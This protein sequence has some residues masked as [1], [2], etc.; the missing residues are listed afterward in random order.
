MPPVTRLGD[1]VPRPQKSCC[2]SEREGGSRPRRT[3]LSRQAEENVGAAL[4]RDGTTVGERRRDAAPKRPVAVVLPPRS[5]DP[6]FVSDTYL[7]FKYS[8]RSRFSP[9]LKSVP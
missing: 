3:A 9:P 7:V 2:G 5:N 4:H 6:E 1:H 8:I